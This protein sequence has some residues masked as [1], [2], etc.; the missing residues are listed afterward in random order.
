MTRRIAVVAVLAAS[1]FLLSAVPAAA[2][3]GPIPGWGGFGSGQGEFKY[4]SGVAVDQAGNVYVADQLNHRVQKFTASGGFV[5]EWGGLGSGDGEFIRPM[6]IAVDSSGVVY[7]TDAG[8]HRVQRF[9]SSG[10]FL[11]AWGSKWGTSGAAPSFHTPTAIAVDASGN[12]LV[13]DNATYLVHKVTPDGTELTAWGQGPGDSRLRL[14]M[15]VAVDGTGNVY[16][17]EPH[18]GIV[19]FTADG[20]FLARW[21]QGGTGIA[22][23][24]DG[25]LYAANSGVRPHE[26]R[27]RVFSPEGTPVT[28]FGCRLGQPLGIAFAPDGTLYVAASRGHEIRAFAAGRAEMDCEPPSVEFA[29][30]PPKRTSKRVARFVFESDDPGAHF[31]CAI[32]GDNFERCKRRDRFRVGTGNHY[33]YVRAV[34]ATGNESSLKSYR[35]RVTGGR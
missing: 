27:I 14:P 4:P 35:W 16:V 30:R 19:K 22:I 2:A 24:P 11:G 33:V 17:S 7:V 9:S 31:E 6:G 12:L 5:D 29:K 25:N 13:V 34:D 32:D 20:G 10:A 21:T 1:A 23:G 8:N 26:D 15:S 3:Y 18:G 28:S